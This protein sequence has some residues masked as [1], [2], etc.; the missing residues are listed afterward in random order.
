MATPEEAAAGHPD[1]GSGGEADGLLTRYGGRRRTLIVLAV[2]VLLV[3]AYGQRHRLELNYWGGDTPGYM[4]VVQGIRQG[5]FY[6][7]ARLPLYPLFYLVTASV[8]TWLTLLCQHLMV[9]ASPFLVYFASLRLCRHDK[10]A[11]LLG[12]LSVA[13]YDNTIYTAHVLPTVLT[14]FLV[15]AWAAS[16]ILV[17]APRRRWLVS[18]ALAALICLTKPQFFYLLLCAYLFCLVIRALPLKV[19]LA[20][21]VCFSILPVLYNA[22]ARA[23]EGRAVHGEHKVINLHV[24]TMTKPY[25]LWRIHLYPPGDEVVDTLKEVVREVKIEHWSEFTN[26]VKA[27]ARRK[28]MTFLE[29]KREIASVYPKV[30][31]Y[32]CIRR[33]DKAVALFFHYALMKS[34]DYEPRKWKGTKRPLIYVATDFVSGVAALCFALSPF[35]TLIL[36]YAH[37]RR[38][39]WRLEPA[40]LLVPVFALGYMVA[41]HYI[42]GFG[43]RHRLPVNDLLLL[44]DA[45]L[46]GALLRRRRLAAGG[47]ALPE[48]GRAEASGPPDP[49]AA[50]RAAGSPL[51]E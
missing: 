17:A 29:A 49:A 13:Y 16:L 30:F 18:G 38:R 33:P 22:G 43:G 31:L 11:L 41:I 40:L 37:L 1:A 44:C 7:P 34:L 15:T 12:A 10:A 8:G 47:E 45:A 20:T 6:H 50:G 19:G 48:G 42:E 35:A 21:I 14:R 51:P 23:R 24:K 3:H 25:A 4:E 32:A 9:L 28:D 36:L 2:F 5:D 39:R 27:Y 26:Y 46:L